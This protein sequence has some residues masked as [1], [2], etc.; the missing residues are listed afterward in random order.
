M[1]LNK[2]ANL[3]NCL[4]FLRIALT[5]IFLFCV[6]SDGY[7]WDVLAFLVFSFAKITDYFDG[8]LARKNNQ[9]TTLGRFLDPLADKI[10]VISAL[11]AFVINRLVVWWLIVPIIVRDIYV[12]AMRIRSISNGGVLRTSTLAKW[13]T[14]TQF[15]VVILLLF[16]LGFKD[17]VFLLSG[18]QFETLSEDKV[19]LF[20]NISMAIVLLLTTISGFHYAFFSKHSVGEMGVKTK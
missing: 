17:I 16:I 11:V 8:K 19:F 6:F 15:V 2:V 13:K 7:Y 3:P 20:A 10:L 9:I 1:N 12:T 14:A 4:S 5:P 18:N